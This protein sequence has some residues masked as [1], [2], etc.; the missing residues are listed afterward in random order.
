MTAVP[1]S[2][3]IKKIPKK[4]DRA[5]TPILPIATAVAINRS[6]ARGL[7]HFFSG[8]NGSLI[9]S[10][11][12]IGPGADDGSSRTSTRIVKM[13]IKYAMAPSRNKPSM[14]MRVNKNPPEKAP[15]AQ[16]RLLVARSK[17]T[18]PP[19]CV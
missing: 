6:I 7:I 9:A 10:C 16:P 14:P 5:L 1:A 8:F 19:F 3:S 12:M 15:T 11:S 17:P 4:N 2:S 13:A 18:A